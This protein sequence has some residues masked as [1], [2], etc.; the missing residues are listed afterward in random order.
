MKECDG[1]QGWQNTYTSITSNEYPTETSC[2]G[3]DNNCDGRIDENCDCVDN[4]TQ[5]CGSNIGI[6]QAGIMTC[7]NGEWSICEGEITPRNEICGNGIDEDCDGGDLECDS[8]CQDL[9]QDGYDNCSPGTQGD[10]G[11]LMDCDDNEFYANPGIGYDTCDTVD[12]NCNGQID[13]GC[14]D[15]N[16]GY[17]DGT[18]TI[19]RNNSMCLNTPF[20]D[21]RYGDDCDD[22]EFW[23]NPG[24]AET[25]DTLDNNCNE[26]IDEGCDDDGDGFC[27]QEKTIYRTN[28]M[29]PRTPYIE[30]RYGNDCNDTASAINPGVTEICSNSIDDNCDG[31]VDENCL[32]IR[33]RFGIDAAVVHGTINFPEII[34]EIGDGISGANAICYFEDYP[35]KTRE[36]LKM[37]DDLYNGYKAAGRTLQVNLLSCTGNEDGGAP[38][39]QLPDDLEAYKDWIK[40][41][42]NKYKGNIFYYQI[43]SEPSSV[44]FTGTKENFVTMLNAGYDA[45]KEVDPNAIVMTSGWS[46]L[47]LYIDDPSEQ[48]LE[49]ILIYLE[50]NNKT[51]YTRLI[52]LLDTFEYVLENGKYDVVSINH[53]RYYNAATGI[54]KKI[55]KYSQKPIIFVDM[56]SGPA[57]A[58]FLVTPSKYYPDYASYYLVLEDRDHPNYE[59]VKNIVEAEH[60]RVLVKKSIFAFAKGV[61]KVFISWTVDTQNFPVIMWNHQGLLGVES[62]SP[63]KV[64]KKP[65]FYTSKLLVSKI[66]K[67]I[68]TE[69]L[70]DYTYKFLFTD[71]D[72][73]YVLWSDDGDKNIDLSSH[74]DTNNILITRIVTEQGQTEPKTEQGQANSILVNNTPIFIE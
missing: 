58:G 45:I 67:F 20:I 11:S 19:Y 18:K 38:V 14:D 48:E 70:N 63:A 24:G 49:D 47:G 1:T 3:L 59:V 8:N 25:C 9:D 40:G 64:R 43:D 37:L 23:A 33:D 31:Q 61:D 71:K 10:D 39:T 73:V 4:T 66:D 12:N 22:N 65:A 44:A 72:P 2:D 28:S 34:S 69:Q 36:D 55:R 50:T 29:C 6:C 7:Q 41:I 54:V 13:E 42:V 35:I 57:S 74:F 52:W 46:F 56:M 60:S 27:N 16:D 17:C 53:N 26:Q 51:I 62:L 32:A 30:G 15:D 21:G 68:S 5:D